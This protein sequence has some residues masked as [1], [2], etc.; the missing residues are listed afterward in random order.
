MRSLLYGLRWRNK[1]L[2]ENLYLIEDNGLKKLMRE[3]TGKKD[4]QFWIGQA[5]DEAVKQGRLS[6][7]VGVDDQG[8]VNRGAISF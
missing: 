6:V 7:S 1:A 2:I 4:G 5:F 3:F 8:R